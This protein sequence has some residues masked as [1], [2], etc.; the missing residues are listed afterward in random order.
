MSKLLTDAELELMTV[1]WDR[2][3]STTREVL[4]AL[5]DGRAYTTV[6]TLLRILVDK[7]FLEARPEGRSHRYAPRLTRD[8]Y[9]TRNLDHVVAGLF[10]GDPLGLV[11]RLVDAERLDEAQLEDLKALVD[12]ELGGGKKA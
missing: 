7:D 3:P 10:G 11:R 2:G 8:A 12:R 9:Q 6:S 1:L 5:D 4:D